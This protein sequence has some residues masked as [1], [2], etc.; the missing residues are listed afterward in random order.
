MGARGEVP[1]AADALLSAVELAD[2]ALRAVDVRRRCP[3]DNL[4][5]MLQPVIGH[6]GAQ[7]DW[8]L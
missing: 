7:R 3:V 1:L 2:L 5:A 8:E 6:E 4:E